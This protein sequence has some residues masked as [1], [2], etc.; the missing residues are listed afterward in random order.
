MSR[1]RRRSGNAFT[2]YCQLID[3]QPNTLVMVGVGTNGEEYEVFR[4]TW[5][6]DFE[7]IGIEANPQ[8]CQTMKDKW[9]GLLIEKAIWNQPCTKQLHCKPRWKDGSSLFESKN[10]QESRYQV[11]V[12]CD[13][14][15]HIMYDHWDSKGNALWLDC[16]GAELQ[17]LQGGE[18]FLKTVDVINVELTSLGRGVDWCDPRKV[19]E[20]LSVRGFK[21]FACHTIRTVLGQRDLIYLHDRI[22]NPNLTQIF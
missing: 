18:Q 10:D 2:E 5:G 4:E 14:L 15:D 7:L 11:D 9:P 1:I 22:F 13:T 17:A 20:F 3:W 16:E 12:E 21:Q 19:H 8:V 6:R